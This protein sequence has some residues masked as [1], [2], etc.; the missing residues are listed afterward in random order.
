MKD[1]YETR[2]KTFP[3]VNSARMRITIDKDGKPVKI[4]DSAEASANNFKPSF[5]RMSSQNINNFI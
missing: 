3:D 2:E 4:T 1:N 5:L